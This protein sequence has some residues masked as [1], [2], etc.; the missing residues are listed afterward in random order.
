SHA[1]IDHS[2]RLPLLVKQGYTG[3]IYAH[4]AT[5]DFCYI[6]L[7]DSAYLNERDAELETRKRQRKGLSAVAPL[8]RMDDALRAYRQLVAVPSGAR[9]EIAP[10]IARRLKD[11]G[12]IMGSAIV[13]LWGREGGGAERKLVFSGDLGQY[14]SPILRDPEP[15][16]RADLL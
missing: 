7:R 8:Y 1:H 3:P 15:I 16:E 6:M 9:R 4:P 2:G 13:E 14:D 12:H 11:A 10:G 5:V